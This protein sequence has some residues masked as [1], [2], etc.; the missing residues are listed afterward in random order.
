ML[1]RGMQSR[2]VNSTR[3]CVPAGDTGLSLFFSGYF[4]VCVSSHLSPGFFFN[5]CLLSFTL[6]PCR[7]SDRNRVRLYI[8]YRQR[9]RM[10]KRVVA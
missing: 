1:M 6:S 3:A 8:V 4:F 9:R 5:V 2:L 7:G 10:I